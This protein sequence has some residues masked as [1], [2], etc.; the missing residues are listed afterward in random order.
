MV[1]AGWWC[2]LWLWGTA[3]MRVDLGALVIGPLGSLMLYFG[4]VRGLNQAGVC[5]C[6]SQRPKRGG[7]WVFFF[8]LVWA[9]LNCFFFVTFEC[10]RAALTSKEA[11][12]KVLGCKVFF[13]YVWSFPQ[14]TIVLQENIPVLLLSIVPVPLTHKQSLSGSHA[15]NVLSKTPHQRVAAVEN[16][17]RPGMDWMAKRKLADLENTLYKFPPKLQKLTLQQAGRGK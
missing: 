16:T 4:S 3:V 14:A 17:L 9:F 2:C 6:K 12:L 1:G 11:Q 10:L 15:S 8:L 7:V 5:K 13:W